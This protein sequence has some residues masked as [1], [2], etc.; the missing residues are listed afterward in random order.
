MSE[1]TDVVVVG[2][3]QAGLAVSH[4]LTHAGIEHV[5]LERDRIAQAWRGRWESF[6]LVTPNWSVQLPGHHYDGE[7]PD[8]FMPRDDI[9]A[10]IEG[11][12]KRFDAPVREGVQVTSVEPSEEGFRVDT[13]AGPVA[14]RSVV[15][16]TGSYAT[17]NRPGGATLPPDLLQLDVEGYRAPEDLPAG[18]VLIVGSGQ[19]GCQL[20]EEL[21]EAGR[22]VFLA[23]GRAGWGPRRLG[24]R[25]LV[26]W[27]VESG[28]FDQ[29][30]RTLPNPQARLIPNPIATG[31]GG[32]H[33]L[34]P[35]TLRAMGVTLL[36]HFLGAQAGR[37]RFAPD[38]AATVAW[39]DER[40]RDLMTL[41]RKTVA[42]QG[43]PMPDIE[44]PPPFDATAPEEVDLTGFGAVI[45][46]GGFRPDYGSLVRIPAAFD[47]MGFPVQSD[48]ASSVVPGLYFV[49]TH[50][51]R[52][53]KS[54]VLYGV[55]EDAAIVAQAI[56]ERTN[57]PA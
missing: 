3:G 25:D 19:S 15:L 54:A 23:C 44:D 40:Y 47:E 57:G 46:A 28:F 32:G 31:H 30:V 2:G 8:G 11:Y 34:H 56:V 18:P 38:L 55:G 14:G 49:G 1:R 33:D 21:L 35:R 13:S 5:V 24:G 4:E 6:C 20:A 39:G 17:A 41:V 45:F 26:W 12:A 52:K 7:D 10:Y 48:G 9:V 29:S 36:G 51:L 43:I 22:E 37:A 50:F 16:A 42:E 53:R 27:I